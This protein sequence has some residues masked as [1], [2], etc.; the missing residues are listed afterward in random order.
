VDQI[1]HRRRS[2]DPLEI[3]GV[4]RG[5]SLQIGSL[6]RHGVDLPGGERRMIEKAFP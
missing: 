1:E 5:G 3:R 4:F 2:G 6:H